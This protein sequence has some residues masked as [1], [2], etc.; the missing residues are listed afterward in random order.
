MADL[1]V[2]E[3][4]LPHEWRPHREFLSALAL[5]ALFW[6]LPGLIPDA[7]DETHIISF[8]LLLL[9]VFAVITVPNLAGCVERGNKV[10]SWPAYIAL[11][12]VGVCVSISGA[13]AGVPEVANTRLGPVLVWVLR[14][15]GIFSGALMVAHVR[16][17][18]YAHL[19]AKAPPGRSL[20]SFSLLLGA[21]TLGIFVYIIEALIRPGD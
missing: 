11:L 6:F 2:D 21:A 12:L 10:R 4:T 7:K 8:M 18:R 19:N 15:T 5:L 20:L 3:A 17:K 16:G 14:A 13:I 9:R 1:R